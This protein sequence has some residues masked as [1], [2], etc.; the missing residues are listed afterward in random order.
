[1]DKQF[2]PATYA[3]LRGS[4][5]DWL[6]EHVDPETGYVLDDSLTLENAAAQAKAVGDA[7]TAVTAALADKAD[8]S[9]VATSEA[10]TPRLSVLPR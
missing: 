3:L 1:M 6:S 10:E 5:D 9:D 4:I 8:K 2:S 7:L